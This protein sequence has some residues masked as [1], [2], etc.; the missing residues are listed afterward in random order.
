MKEIEIQMVYDYFGIWD[1]EKILFYH[2]TFWIILT[3]IQISLQ[4]YI[5]L[6][7]F[8][9]KSD[10][11]FII[12]YFFFGKSIHC[13]EQSIPSPCWYNTVWYI[14]KHLLIDSCPLH[15]MSTRRVVAAIPLPLLIVDYAQEI[16]V[17][18][19]LKSVNWRSPRYTWYKLQ[20]LIIW[21]FKYLYT[22]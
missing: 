20:V 13:K 7:E 5:L 19:E 1:T 8:T 3:L 15:Q 14:C 21:F 22:W 9:L 10:A 6:S 16:E 12:L 4:I 11:A 17:W 18:L 2:I